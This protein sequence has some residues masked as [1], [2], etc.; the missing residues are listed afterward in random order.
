[1]IATTVIQ[2][3][4]SVSPCPRRAFFFLSLSFS[5]PGSVFT[6]GLLGVFDYGFDVTKAVARSPKVV[7]VTSM[8]ASMLGLKSRL[9]SFG[10]SGCWVDG[11]FGVFNP[12]AMC[13]H[14]QRPRTALSCSAGCVSR[15]PTAR[16]CSIPHLSG[17]G[18]YR[19]F[20]I[21]L[22]TLYGRSL[23]MASGALLLSVHW[24]RTAISM[25]S[26]RPLMT[27]AEGKM[28]C[29]LRLRRMSH[30][31]RGGRRNGRGF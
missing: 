31:S 7:Q 1:M 10:N 25:W 23:R 21:G 16:S 14:S 4:T 18:E 8:S 27:C 20:S 15:Q 29:H 24:V 9:G 22:M 26:R 3:T 2:T 5:L 19:I 30:G 17:S 28:P 12:N 11:K 13:R 6:L